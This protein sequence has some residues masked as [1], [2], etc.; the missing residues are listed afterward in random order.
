M[1]YCFCAWHCSYGWLSLR[2]CQAFGPAHPRPGSPFTFNLMP[3]SPCAALPCPCSY[4]KKYNYQ[5]KETGDVITFEGIYAPDRGQAA[6]VTFYTFVGESQVSLLLAPGDA[7][8]RQHPSL[9][10]AVTNPNPT[11]TLSP[12]VPNRVY[13]GIQPRQGCVGDAWRLVCA[14]RGFAGVL[15]NSINSLMFAACC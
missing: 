3:G 12:M 11:S 1:F 15:C 6:A 4:F 8:T 14:S 10:V 2:I 7:V 9:C 5:I 13:H